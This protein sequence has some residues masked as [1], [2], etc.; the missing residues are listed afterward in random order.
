MKALQ[1]LI[2]M[3]FLAPILTGCN[4][5]ELSKTGMSVAKAIQ[6][7]H[8]LT[9]EEATTLVKKAGRSKNPV[10]VLTIM[11]LALG[12]TKG[13]PEWQSGKNYGVLAIHESYAGMKGNSCGVRTPEDLF[14][15]N[16]SFCILDEAISNMYDNIKAGNID[17]KQKTMVKDHNN[18]FLIFHIYYGGNFIPFNQAYQTYAAIKNMSSLIKR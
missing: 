7:E 10:P 8:G 6:K 11:D 18:E 14:N 2:I 13:D 15:V 3:V 9:I 17:E 5:P 4:E 12:A 1:A 16:K